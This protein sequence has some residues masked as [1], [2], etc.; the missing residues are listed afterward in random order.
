M[1][2]HGGW[3]KLFC[4]KSYG[5]HALTL[6]HQLISSVLSAAVDMLRTLGRRTLKPM[7]R[8]PVQIRTFAVIAGRQKVDVAARQQ[9]RFFKVLV[10]FGLCG[11]AGIYTYV[12]RNPCKR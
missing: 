3:R 12:R 5:Q 10:G 7:L 9:W 1:A 6:R 11:A 8:L 2:C 4:E